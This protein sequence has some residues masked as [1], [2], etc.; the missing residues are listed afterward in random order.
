MTETPP[1]VDDGTNHRQSLWLAWRPRV[2]RWLPEQ[3]TS[4]SDPTA[5]HTQVGDY[6]A[7]AFL[8][9]IVVG[10]QWL[11]VVLIAPAVLLV[12]LLGRSRN[13]A[14]Y[15]PPRGEVQQRRTAND[16]TARDHEEPQ[17]SV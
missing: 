13:Q 5:G 15:L 3:G 6:E 4:I 2:P 16:R 14:G 10:L 12:R 1:E 17:Q 9:H 11:I 8:V 7:I